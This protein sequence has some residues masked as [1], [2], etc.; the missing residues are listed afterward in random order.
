MASVHYPPRQVELQTPGSFAGA[1]CFRHVPVGRNVETN[2]AR[3]AEIR[4]KAAP[5]Q[6]LGSHALQERSAILED[7]DDYE[8]SWNH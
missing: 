7:E 2:I 3:P 6:T 8:D 5:L 1:A 4:A